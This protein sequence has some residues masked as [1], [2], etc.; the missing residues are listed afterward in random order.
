MR[1]QRT[2]P[3]ATSSARSITTSNPGSNRTKARATPGPASQ[4]R[5]RSRYSHYRNPDLARPAVERGQARAGAH[6]CI[7]RGDRRARAHAVLW[8]GRACSCRRQRGRRPSHRGRAVPGAHRSRL[9]HPGRRRDLLGRRGD[10]R[11]GIQ[12]FLE[13]SESRG[14]NGHRCWRPMPRTSRVCSR[15]KNIR[16]SRAAADASAPV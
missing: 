13:D 15:S 16:G 14:R 4:A 10:G 11:Q 1:S 3:R 9:H 7:S 6:G 12:G 5:C 8:Q 2:A